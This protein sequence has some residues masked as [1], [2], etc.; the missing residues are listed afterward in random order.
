M[1]KSVPW[2]MFLLLILATGCSKNRGMAGSS[3]GALK[4]D[5][6]PIDADPMTFLLQHQ[7]HFRKVIGEQ[8]GDCEEALASLVRFISDHKQE[9]R[10]QALEK[11]DPALPKKGAEKAMELV[12]EFT[13]RCPE[14]VQR[15]NQALHELVR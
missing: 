1:C 7:A 6:Q 9:F 14:Q 13:D 5:S 15:L 2:A 10:E 4:T 11:P 8:A 12:M 3:D